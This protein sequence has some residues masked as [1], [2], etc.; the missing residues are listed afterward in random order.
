MSSIWYKPLAILAWIQVCSIALKA[1]SEE[2]NDV[3][4][5]VQFILKADDFSSRKYNLY[6]VHSHACY[7]NWV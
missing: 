7:E 5:T 6:A 1:S 2:N 4:E 3:L